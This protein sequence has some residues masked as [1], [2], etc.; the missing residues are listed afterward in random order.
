[1]LMGGKKKKICSIRGQKALPE[2]IGSQQKQP[3]ER[4]EMFYEGGGGNA[5]IIACDLGNDIHKSL[6]ISTP[7]TIN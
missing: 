5:C 2:V 3:R 1:M 4:G 6:T 7:K